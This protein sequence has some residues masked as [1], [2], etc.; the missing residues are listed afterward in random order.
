MAALRDGHLPLGPMTLPE[1]REVIVA[2]ARAAGLTL[3]P[4]LV[5]ILLRDMGV[6]PEAAEH[7]VGPA[8][9]PGAL[10]LLSHALL[11]TWQ[12]REGNALTVDGYRLTGGIYGAVAATAERVYRAPDAPHRELA[13]RVLLRMVSV[14]ADDAASRRPV[15]VRHLPDARFPPEATFAVVEAFARARLLTVDADHVQLAHEALLRAWPRLR[16]WILAGR[17]GLRVHQ[18][19]TD[20]A[21][22]WERED[23][24]PSLLHRGVRLEA[25]QDWADTGEAAL[26][27]LEREFLQM[28]LAARSAE[29]AEAVRRGRRLRRLAVTL[30]VLLVFAAG[31]TAY[32]VSAQQS[33]ARQRNAALSQKV[34]DEA[35]ELRGTDPALAAQL[36]LASY[37][38]SGTVES[39]SSLLPAFAAPFAGR[40][41]GHGDH[42]NEAAFGADGRTVATAG[43]DGVRL[44]DV[45]DPRCPRPLA[46]PAGHTGAVRGG[47][48]VPPRRPRPGQL[49]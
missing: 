14:S 44:W 30:T 1:L 11:T 48:G 42:V 33:A 32:A 23:R 46:A 12:R 36:S 9:E 26:T 3:E 29:N 41:T 15:D 39:R 8:H 27:H 38:L 49:G 4:G 24:D 6:R 34:A 2:P 18:Q 37:R 10:P 45:A 17:A 35:A 22:A 19:L 7:G 28:S 13:R 31:T 16:E 40:L 21:Q 43:D 47:G 25:A 5:E 20:A